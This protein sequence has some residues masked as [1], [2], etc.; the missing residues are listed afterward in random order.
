MPISAGEKSGDSEKRP[1][2]RPEGRGD[3]VATV[4][5]P[6]PGVEVAEDVQ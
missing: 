2:H 3:A 6:A 4:P 1:A 5:G